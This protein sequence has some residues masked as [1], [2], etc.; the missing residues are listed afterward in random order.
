M[1]A[2][3]ASE[4]D[5]ARKTSARKPGK[6]AKA[7]VKAAGEI[8]KVDVD[9]VVVKAEEIVEELQSK[10]G[11]PTKYKPEYARIAAALCR[12]GATDF[13]LAEEFEVTTV[14]IWNWQSK[15]EEFFNAL[16]EGKAA[17]DDRIE[18]S[19]AQRAT[20][21]A[22]HTEKVFQFQ[23]S[24]VRAKVVEHV[25]AD[26]GAAK[27]WLTNRRP[28]KWLELSKVEH[29]SPGDFDRMTD[30]ELEAFI[31]AEASQALAIPGG[32]GKGKTRH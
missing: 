27:L 12:R 9:P 11:R 21:Y 29:G 32:S 26:I 7:S 6:G 10:M 8:K 17:F 30:E 20:G 22:Y 24:I 14:T 4:C 16:R 28:D 3:V 15:Y 19:L 5:M 1:A 23:G 31:K 13:E 2:Q 18:R 25:P